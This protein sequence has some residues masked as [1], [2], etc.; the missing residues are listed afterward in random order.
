MTAYTS[1]Q[2]GDFN[3]AATWGGSGTPTS[4]GDSFTI[5]GGHVVQFNVDLSGLASGLGASTINGTLYFRRSAGTYCLKL[6]GTLTVGTSGTLDASDGSGGAYPA[7]CTATI[8]LNGSYSVTVSGSGA[9]NLICGEPTHQY[10][11]LTQAESAGATTLHVDTDVT[12]DPLWASGALVRVD[13]VNQGVQSE[14]RT[15]SGAP[16]ASSIALTAGLTA[17]KLAD[18]CVI[19]VARNVKILGTGSGTGIN[20]GGTGGVV[21]AEIRQLANGISGATGLTLGGTITNCGTAGITGGSGSH[22]IHAAVSGCATGI[23]SGGAHVI[24]GIISGCTTGTS[25][26]SQAYSHVALVISGCAIGATGGGQNRFVNT[27]VSGCTSGISGGGGHL[28]LNATLKNNTQ[29]LNATNDVRADNTLLESTTEFSGYNSSGRT[30]ATYSESRDH[31]Q[32]AGAFRSWC[33]GGIVSSVASP[34]YDAS[35]VRSYNAVCESA[36][37]PAFLQRQ[38]WVPDGGSLFVRCYARKDASMSY[39]LPRLWVF[40]ADKEPL[41]SGTPDAEMTMDAADTVDTWEV[42]TAAVSNASG[43]AKA[44]VVRMLAQNASGNVYFDPE[45]TVSAGV[46][47]G[48]LVNGA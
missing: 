47:R 24:S 27:E 36:D 9:V 44:Y 37:Y 48:R 15:I 32:V 22:V 41:V 43:A 19:L 31:D 40:S 28:L 1:A 6:A 21:S 5:A 18:A 13:N 7:N 4:S 17:A 16:T 8:L 42:L 25:P 34:V 33:K 11:R 26:G 12:G 14:E 35:R 45:I 46:S 2:S 29:D 38:V 20:G 23:S 39:R 10:V 3:D 30:L